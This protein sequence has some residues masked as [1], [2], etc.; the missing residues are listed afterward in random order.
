MLKLDSVFINTAD[1]QKL[2]DFYQKI[3]Q[4]KTEWEED[5]YYGFNLESGGLLIGKHEK[6]KGIN[7]SPDRIMFNLSTSEVVDEF[8]R[9]VDLGA[10]VVAQP[11]HPKQAESMTIATLADPDGN[12]FQLATPM[13]QSASN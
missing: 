7:T 11:Y 10:K 6:V 9:M 1:S 2:A 13:S 5:G 3:F 12:Y 8:K 4:K